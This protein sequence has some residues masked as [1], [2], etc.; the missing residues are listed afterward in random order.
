MMMTMSQVCTLNG[1]SCRSISCLR[2]RRRG[3]LF[4]DFPV[5]GPKFMETKFEPI[6]VLERKSWIVGVVASRADWELVTQS[7]FSELDLCELR[8]DLLITEQIQ[9]DEY[10]KPL[11]LPKILT[12][13][14]PREGGKEGL[15]ENERFSETVNCLSS[16]FCRNAGA[17]TDG[18]MGKRNRNAISGRDL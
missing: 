17:R 8:M 13:R 1:S 12:I 14:D 16:R 15:S 7:D 10:L 9:Q 2:P 5:D 11:P 4:L 6:D 3:C 18:T